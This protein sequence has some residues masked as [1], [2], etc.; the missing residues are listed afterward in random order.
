MPLNCDCDYDG[1]YAY[2][3]DGRPED[4]SVYSMR[5]GRRCVADACNTLIRPGNECTVHSRWRYPHSDVEDRIYGGCGD[6][7]VQIPLPP[8]Y[9][10]TRCANMYLAL[11]ELG[12][13]I[14]P[15]ENLSA[16]IVEYNALRQ[17]QPADWV[18]CG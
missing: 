8:Q 18:P 14:T 11:A 13:C 16:L 4:L 9:L 17:H 5:R 3:Y 10:C 6:F 15:E 2:W 12:Y 7:D 1:D